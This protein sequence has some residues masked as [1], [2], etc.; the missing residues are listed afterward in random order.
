MMVMIRVMVMIM[1]IVMMVTMVI[2]VMII[3]VTTMMI[4]IYYGPSASSHIISQGFSHVI[5]AEA[6]TVRSCDHGISGSV[7]A[8]RFALVCFAGIKILD[9]RILRR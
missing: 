5:A 3:V 1:V 2:V 9:A 6:A 4:I 7:L 8:K